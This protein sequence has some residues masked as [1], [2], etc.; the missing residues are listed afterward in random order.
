M[1]NVGI[2]CGHLEYIFY[3]HLVMWSFGIYFPVLVYCVKKNLETL[4]RRA[5]NNLKSFL[6][7][8]FLILFY[9]W[10]RI[11]YIRQRGPVV[12]LQVVKVRQTVLGFIYV[13]G[14]WLKHLLVRLEKKCVSILKF[15]LETH[16]KPDLS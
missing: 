11:A 13:A 15:Q 14:G 12:H 7:V 9:N 5:T 10:F 8:S 2:F 16:A 1:E 4:V 6:C 3:S